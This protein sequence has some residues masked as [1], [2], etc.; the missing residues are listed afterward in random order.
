MEHTIIKPSYINDINDRNDESKRKF[1][2]DLLE[3]TALSI[4]I[5]IQSSPMKRNSTQSNHTAIASNPLTPTATAVLRLKQNGW[6]PESLYRVFYHFKVYIVK[7]F[8]F[9]LFSVL[10]FIYSI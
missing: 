10:F 8:F 1:S 5:K 9:F 6:L 2:E 4:N 7:N 3:T